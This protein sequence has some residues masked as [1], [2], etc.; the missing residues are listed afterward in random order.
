MKKISLFFK[1]NVLYMFRNKTRFILTLLGISIGLC[2]YILGNVGVDC[3]LQGL[4]RDAYNFDSDGVLVYDD[5]GEAIEKIQNYDSNIRINRYCCDLSH[6]TTDKDY[7]YKGVSLNNSINLIGMD[8]K[9]VG[10]IVPYMKNDDTIS[11]AKA[12]LLY[13]T[14]FSDDDIKKGTNSIVIE[15]STALFWF[16]KENAVGEY[17]D[18]ISPHGYDRFIVIG[19]IEDLP[20]RRSDNMIFNKTIQQSNVE[21][22]SNGSIAFTPYKYLSDMAE[23]VAIDWYTFDSSDVEDE[24]KLNIFIE[25]LKKASIGRRSSVNI[26]TQQDLIEE[27]SQTER[28]LRVF[29]NTIII[30]LIAISGFMIVTVYIFSVKERTYE[31]GVRRALGASGFDIVFQFVIEGI[32][33]SLV[34]FVVVLFICTVACNLTTAI[35]VSKFYIDLR[36]VFSWKLILSTI[37]LTVLQGILFSMTPALIASK[38]RPTEAI[39]WD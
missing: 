12:R 26:I 36:F 33:T 18:V 1:L 38:I 8:C 30:A 35:L 13:G 14:D 21:K 15:K 25:N 31:I 11:L 20:A 5:K 16:Q 6:F 32:I 24:G 29:I 22:I 17:V 7:I 34:A 23:N 37:G 3:Y 4:Y 39:R 9:V 19:V 27:A 28:T 2:I 10:N